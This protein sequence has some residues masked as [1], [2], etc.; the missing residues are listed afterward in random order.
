MAA[1]K[2]KP[3]TRAT[4]QE[5]AQRQ[6]RAAEPKPEPVTCRSCPYFVASENTLGI[7]DCRRYPTFVRRRTDEWCAEHP[8]W[9]A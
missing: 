6:Q 5:L 2:R 3:F 1:R 8:R 4:P 9:S 7:G